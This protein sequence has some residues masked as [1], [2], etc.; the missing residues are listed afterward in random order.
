[1]KPVPNERITPYDIGDTI[2]SRFEVHSRN[3]ERFRI[4]A[5][6]Q[7]QTSFSTCIGCV[8]DNVCYEVK[9]FKKRLGRH[10]LVLCPGRFGQQ[11]E[12]IRW[13]PNMGE[14]V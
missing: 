13:I 11:D 7:C 10:T 6:T 9:R 1:M 3:P 12:Y 8:T 14:P 4:I 5:L 2:T